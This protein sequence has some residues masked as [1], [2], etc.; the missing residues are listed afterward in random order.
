LIHA[1]VVAPG[2]IFLLVR[3]SILWENK[4]SFILSSVKSLNHFMKPVFIFL[5]I[6]IAASV[7]AQENVTL[8]LF[9]KDWEPAKNMKQAVYIMQE[10]KESDS[11]Y[12]CRYYRKEGPMI[13][14]EIFRDSAYE[15]P[16]GRF[17]WYNEKGQL[18]SL[19]TVING[20]KDKNWFYNMDDSGRARVEEYF[21]N[22]R[23]KSRTNY[24]LRTI[25]LADGTKESLDKPKPADT[26]PAKVFTVVQHAAEFPGGL[27]AWTAYLGRNLH[28]PSRLVDISRP[29]TKAMVGVEFIVNKTGQIGDLFIWRSY[30][31]SADLEAMRAIRSGPNWKPADQ[32]GKNVI[33]RH[34]QTITF[35][36]GY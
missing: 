20:H 25:T 32:N 22:G 9:N 29:G 14:W 6:S 3:V 12:I 33:Y 26:V 1:L 36:V 35:V 30:E 17:A 15:I 21:E 34:R 24:A 10:V 16:N 2:E 31:W 8:Y 28:T 19:G 7:Y 11:V 5:F 13:K 4:K 27:N 23:F 18:D